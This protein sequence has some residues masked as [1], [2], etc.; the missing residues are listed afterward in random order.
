[1]RVTLFFLAVVF[2]TLCATPNANACSPNACANLLYPRAG[3]DVPAN[4]TVFMYSQGQ[5]VG[6]SPVGVVTLIDAFDGADIAMPLAMEH[7]YDPTII[8]FSRPLSVGHDYAFHSTDACRAYGG[9]QVIHVTDAAPIPTTLGTLSRSVPILADVGLRPGGT[10]CTDVARAVTVNVDVVLS[11]EASKWEGLLVYEP[12]VDGFRYL[13]EGSELLVFLR[14]GASYTGFGTVQLASI[15]ARST[16]PGQHDS[17]YYN[18]NTALSEGD[19]EV[20]FRATIAGTDISIESEP[21]TVNLRCLDVLPADQIDTEI[22][23]AG[24]SDAGAPDAGPPDEAPRS[25]GACSVAAIGATTSSGHAVLIMFA[26][27]PL[28]LIGRRR[29]YL[30]SACLPQTNSP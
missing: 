10:Y 21:T 1:M 17:R 4:A 19:H 7:E 29:E 11:E 6:Q 16:D 3:F 30:S 14:E 5:H 26:L 24:V 12:Y 8:A 23:D 22:P 28:L 9:D 25:A 27:A 15:C 2:S 18:R 13:G 20:V